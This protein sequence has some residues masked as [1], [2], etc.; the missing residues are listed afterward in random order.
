MFAR[1]GVGVVLTQHRTDPRL[2]PLGLDL[3]SA[4]RSA[5]ETID[6]LVASTPHHGWRQLAVVDRHDRVAYSHGTKLQPIFAG[7]QGPGVVA[8][9]NILS[10][11]GV[12]AAEIDAFLARPERH[13]GAR[14]LDALHAGLAGGGECRPLRSAALLVV[15]K[16]SFPLVDLRIDDHPEPLDALSGL[17]AAY[18]PK[19][20]AFVQ[21]AVD[22]DGA[23]P[24]SFSTSGPE[25]GQR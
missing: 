5:S 12:C 4:G 7:A 20:D 11:A 8:I 23:G 1:S 17:W 19:M 22:P 6:A 24:A 18:E 25:A 16:E 21:W 9:G 15:D 2:G 13:I 10:N 14:L 3:L